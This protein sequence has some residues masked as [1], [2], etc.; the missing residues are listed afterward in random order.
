MAG[1]DRRQRR[2]DPSSLLCTYVDC[3]DPAGAGSPMCD[4]HR[5]ALALLAAAR[6]GHPLVP[7][8]LAWDEAVRLARGGVAAI[9]YRRP[10][11]ELMEDVDGRPL[12]VGGGELASG[13]VG[14]A[15]PGWPG[16]DEQGCGFVV[17]PLF[18]ALG[19]VVTECDEPGA[20]L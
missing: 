2:V 14:Y 8:R 12:G 20:Q 16:D 10:D 15:L 5:L 1:T 18:D 11:V 13:L 7:P 9:T 19:P 4:E 6:R 3:E 17:E